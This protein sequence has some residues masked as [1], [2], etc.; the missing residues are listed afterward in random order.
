MCECL[1]RA[2][3]VGSGAHKIVLFKLVEKLFPLFG[4]NQTALVDAGFVSLAADLLGSSSPELVCEA[5]CLLSVIVRNSNV[6]EETPE[7]YILNVYTLGGRQKLSLPFDFEY[8][9]VEADGSD[10][11]L[12]NDDACRVYNYRGHLKFEYTFEQTIESVLPAKGRNTYMLINS[13][14]VQKIRLK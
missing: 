12:Y 4:E 13:Q 8:K 2:C 11:I 9:Y 10:I 14:E 5:M 6:T 7:K 3:E 1:Y